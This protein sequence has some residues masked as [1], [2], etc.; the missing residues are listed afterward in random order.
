M[1]T[2]RYEYSTKFT[3]FTIFIN[4][5]FRFGEHTIFVNTNDFDQVSYE[6]ITKQINNHYLKVNQQDVV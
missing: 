6:D 1:S 2:T 5:D 4:R 3:Y